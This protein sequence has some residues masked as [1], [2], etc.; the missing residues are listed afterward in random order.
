RPACAISATLVIGSTRINSR[1]TPRSRQPPS[2]K[3]APYPFVSFPGRRTDPPAWPFSDRRGHWL[4]VDRA[5][6]GM[7]RG[8]PFV[9]V[10]I[11]GFRNEQ[12]ADHH[13]HGGDHDGIPQPIIDAAVLRVHRQHHRRQQATEPAV[14]DVV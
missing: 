6:A 12:D 13:G 8:I 5:I 1:S 9:Y 11:L 3:A 4:K 14:A 10:T 2:V 7:F